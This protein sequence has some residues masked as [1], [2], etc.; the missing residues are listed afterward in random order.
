MVLGKYRVKWRGCLRTLSKPICDKT[1]VSLHLQW[2]NQG[3]L[4]DGGSTF[5]KKR[6][7]VI[8]VPLKGYFLH[9][10][11]SRKQ[12]T[13]WFPKSETSILMVEERFKLKHA[14]QVLSQ[15]TEKFIHSEVTDRKSD[16]SRLYQTISKAFCNSLLIHSFDETMCLPYD[17]MNVLQRTR[18]SIHQNIKKT[19][20]F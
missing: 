8:Q 16:F 13:S 1:L 3:T 7:S 15:V 5:F 17:M 9:K 6:W 14:N 11:N 2:R 12:L 10:L 4:I 20:V 18:L 19:T